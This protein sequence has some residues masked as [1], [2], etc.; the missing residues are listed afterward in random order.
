MLRIILSCSVAP[1]SVSGKRTGI[2]C[3]CYRY[4]C[5]R[6][7]RRGFTLV[8][9][10]IA[11]AVVA[12]VA[13]IAVPSMRT[14]IQ[15]TRILTETNNLITDI[16]FARSEAVKRVNNVGICA[17]SGGTA[18]D[19]AA[20]WQNGRIVFID[21]NGNGVWDAGE[22]IIRVRGAFPS[23]DMTM[24]ANGGPTVGTFILFGS[25]GTVSAGNGTYPIC[26][27]RG[28]S[29]GREV[30]LSPVGQTTTDAVPA[31]GC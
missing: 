5:Y 11:L 9:L 13:T 6:Y 22:Q 19:A 2:T 14:F 7:V 25:R 16:A 10:V 23:A 20:A 3:S 8:E 27:E 24:S 21:A 29:Y 17:S 26:D 12:I 4:S 18:C 30:T 31:G 1:C 28:A 15:N